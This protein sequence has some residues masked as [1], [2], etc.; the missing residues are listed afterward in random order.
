DLDQDAS[1]YARNVGVLILPLVAGYFAWKR[2]L[3]AGGRLRLTGGFAAGAVAANVYPFVPGGSTEGLTALHL[4]IVLW[5][6]VGVGYAGERWRK[7]DGRMDFIRFSGELFI[8]FVLIALGGGV[9]TAFTAAIFQAIGIDAEPFIESWLLPCGAAGAIVI[10]SWLVEAKQSV[11]ENMAPV[12]TRLFTPLFT[13][14]LLL[15]LGTL[16]WTGR[17]IDIQRNVLIAFDLLLVVVIGLLLYSASARDSRSAP[18]AFD[19]LQVTLVVSALLVDAVA[20]WAIAARITE[21]GFS[22]NRVAAL[23]ENVILLA[24]LAWSAWLYAGFLR[25]TRS[26]TDLERWQTRYLPVYA[27]WA[28]L[29]V[30]VFPPVFG[31]A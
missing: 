21:F 16:L 20:L 15:F 7:V 17:G 5:F 27:A 12:L 14:L 25:G 2:R 30:V 24:N 4:P 1:F 18:D 13:G 19:A 8:Y 31:F 29:V 6:L 10:A 26:F 22:P 28:A 3:D 11:I 9:L 23:G